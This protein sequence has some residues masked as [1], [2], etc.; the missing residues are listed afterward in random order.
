ML[1]ACRRQRSVHVV[2]VYDGFNLYLVLNACRRQRS[3]HRCTLVLSPCHPRCAQRLS[4][5]K[6][7]SLEGVPGRHPVARNHVLNACRRQRSVHG[8][9]DALQG[10]VAEVLNACRRQRSVHPVH[11][12]SL[13][14]YKDVLNACRRQRSVHSHCRLVGAVGG[15]ACSTPVGV[16]D[17][18]TPP[19]ASKFLRRMACSTPVGVKDRFTHA[20][21]HAFLPCRVLN[22]CRRQRSVHI[23]FSGSLTG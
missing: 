10:Q 19:A 12:Y 3:V 23:S 2:G 17:R 8:V 1:N 21:F 4:A 9:P 13:R 5:S 7:G 14:Q 15:R 6:I 22:A 20:G 16:K 18:F 11:R